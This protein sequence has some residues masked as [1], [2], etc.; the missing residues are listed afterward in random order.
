MRYLAIL[1]LALLAACDNTEKY[2]T[3]G[4]SITDDNVVEY[5]TIN[6]LLA[7][8]DSANVK[9]AGEILSTCKMKGCWMN[10]TIG[11]EEM[12]VTFKDYGFFVPKE[13]MEGKHTIMEGTVIRQTTDVA[14]LK[15]F[16]EDQGKSQHEID[17]ITE[18]KQELAFI[19]TGV[20]IER[21]D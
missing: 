15:H 5:A 2:D 6:S 1:L 12:R 11:D 4:A 17:Q 9:L 16:A 10:V 20:L 3:Y 8:S 14:T 13:G 18:P 19:A 21:E 7:N